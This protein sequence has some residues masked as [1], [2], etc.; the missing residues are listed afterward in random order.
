MAISDENLD[1]RNER[2]EQLIPFARGVVRR[3]IDSMRI[4]VYL[5][6]DLES[7][8]YEGLVRAVDNSDTKESVGLKRYASIRIRGAVIDYLRANGYYSR[9][10]YRKLKLQ[11]EQSGEVEHLV[12]Y[13]D[14]SHTETVDKSFNPEERYLQIERCRQIKAV[15]ANLP[16]KEKMIIEAHYFKETPLR[17]LVCEGAKLPCISKCHRR[18]LSR[19]RKRLASQLVSY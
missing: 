1:A 18:G 10:V 15:V 13:L 12:E 11:L 14:E 2:I 6:A 17:D 7:A 4:P 5:Q 3:L 9:S 19:L 8:A 16:E